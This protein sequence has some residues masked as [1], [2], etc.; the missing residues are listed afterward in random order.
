M[1]TNKDLNTLYKYYMELADKI[2]ERQEQIGEPP[3]EWETIDILRGR[4]LCFNQIL[5]DEVKSEQ[6][7]EKAWALRDLVHIYKEGSTTM[8]NTRE[9]FEQLKEHWNDNE[10]KL[11]IHALTDDLI[12][13]KAKLMNIVEVAQETQAMNWQPVFKTFFLEDM[14]I[15]MEAFVKFIQENGYKPT[16][17][18]DWLYMGTDEEGI[19][20]Y[21]Y[22]SHYVEFFKI[23]EVF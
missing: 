2:I 17:G 10:A 1:K 15:P 16:L 3:D 21:A 14:G 8:L 18:L 13:D 12:D 7:R 5:D 23:N 9:L 4:L 6:A 11:I 19:E 22:I 20:Q